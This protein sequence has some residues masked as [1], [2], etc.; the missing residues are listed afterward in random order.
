M[1]PIRR[2]HLLNANMQVSYSGNISPFQ[3][4]EAGP[5]PA[6]C[7]IKYRSPLIAGDLDKSKS[8]PKPMFGATPRFGYAASIDT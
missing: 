5:I 6:T 2:V 8:N 1:L 7:S 4:E 3:G